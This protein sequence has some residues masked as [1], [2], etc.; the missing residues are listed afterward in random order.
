MLF[1]NST[2][3]KAMEN[4]LQ[5]SWLQQ[6]V[7]AQNLANLETPNYKAK[8]VSFSDAMQ[9]ANEQFSNSARY[10]FRTEIE[11]REDTSARLDGNNVDTG[12]ESLVLYKAYAQYS[13][14]T[15]KINGSFSNFRY[16]LTNGP[17]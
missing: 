17:R 14:L 16:V 2:S 6:Q 8:T 1:F 4:G 5:A 7:A 3:F 15:Q 10:S 9:Q 13:Y 11:T 12:K